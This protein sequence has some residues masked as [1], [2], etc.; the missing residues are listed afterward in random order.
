MIRRRAAIFAALV[1]AA[2][3]WWLLH[4]PR[5]LESR[6][7][8]R[9]GEQCSFELAW[10]S[11]STTRLGGGAA[12]RAAADLAVDVDFRGTVDIGAD[13]GGEGTVLTLR[14]SPSADSKLSVGGKAVLAGTALGDAAKVAR[15]ELKLDTN[16]ALRNLR[17]SDDD[18]RVIELVARLVHTRLAPVWNGGRATAWS[19][20]EGNE[21]GRGEV[22][23]RV[24][25]D[26]SLARDWSSYRDLSIRTLVP[27]A[28]S[29]VREATTAWQWGKA[30][31][32]EAVED[33]E[34]TVVRNGAREEIARVLAH[35]KLSLVA[36]S[37]RATAN[38]PQ[39]HARW[40]RVDVTQPLVAGSASSESALDRR[41]AGLTLDAMIEGL[42]HLALVP[43]DPEKAEFLVRAAGLLIEHPEYSDALVPIATGP[44]LGLEG[45]MVVLDVLASVGHDSA[46]AALRD[47]LDHRALRAD[48]LGYNTLV[49][50]LSFV[51]A[52]TDES[53]AWLERE[54]GQRGAAIGTAA[55][56]GAVAGR[57]VASGRERVAR[58]AVEALT[59]S[60][61]TTRDVNR[62]AD[63]LLA[64]GNVR[65]PVVAPVLL[66]ES[67][68]KVAEAR[69]AAAFALRGVDLPQVRDALVELARIQCLRSPS[70]P[71]RRSMRKR[72]KS[73]NLKRSL[74]TSSKG[75][76]PL[77][78]RPRSSRT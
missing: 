45:R 18:S 35:A 37:A 56:L 73:R 9:S 69:A 29:E 27:D 8:V 66:R 25:T 13:D 34:D 26:G 53:L 43:H 61:E 63:L 42:E 15:A 32:V 47:A 40:V 31:A 41:I 4:R 72:S 75:A 67:K 21:V 59:R 3:A 6:S 70:L 24:G 28:S 77:R 54:W 23:Y 33:R 78:R 58:P 12:G 7:L 2:G 14:F 64:L 65:S 20:D 51:S 38:A 50:R 17:V 1:A 36:C 62:R 74:P 52:P 10:E 68:S 44:G 46:Q 55:A 49:Q 22:R 71:T 39:A 19:R 60:V 5:E 48:A 16:G 30:A 76:S 11:R 57:Y